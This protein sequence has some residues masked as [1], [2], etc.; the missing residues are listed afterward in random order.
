MLF[1]QEFSFFFLEVE[2][3]QV[4]LFSWRK[5]KMSFRVFEFVLCCVVESVNG[6]VVV[7]QC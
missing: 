6:V 3:S 2:K 1:F 7:G 4:S 5:W